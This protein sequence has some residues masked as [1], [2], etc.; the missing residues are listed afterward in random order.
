MKVS[1]RF[2]CLRCSEILV[3][4]SISTKIRIWR[5]H[6]TEEVS[7]IFSVSWHITHISMAIL[8]NL[9]RDTDH[10]STKLVCDHPLLWTRFWTRKKSIMNRHI[11]ISNGCSSYLKMRFCIW[12]INL[13]R[14]FPLNLIPPKIWPLSWLWS[15]WS[16]FRV[17]SYL[18]ALW[19]CPEATYNV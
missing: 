6:Q 15:F 7:N 5:F 2:H 17:Q 19:G 11:F 8:I 1:F 12:W 4:L 18:F 3:C 10:N 14:I 13:L 16:M 9:G